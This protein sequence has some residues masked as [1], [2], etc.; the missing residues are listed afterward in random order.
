MAN[1]TLTVNSQFDPFSYQELLQPALMATQA[2]RELEDQYSTLSTEANIWDNLVNKEKDK[3]AYSLYKSF[4]DDLEQQVEQ[5]AREGL[6]TSS[7]KRLLNMKSRYSKDITPLVEAKNALREANTL[8]D[9]AGP[10][11]IFEVSRYNSL[12]DFLGGKTAN[13]RYQS[14]SAIT[15]K[16]AAITEA[17]MKEALQDPGFKEIPEVQQYMIT[18]HT[19]G[20][21]EDLMAAIANNPRAQSKFAAIKKQVMEEVDY[22]NY[23]TYGQA[24]IESAVNTGL[25]AGLDKP[26]RQFM[27]NKVIPPKPGDDSPGTGGSGTSRV[28]RMSKAIILDTEGKVRGEGDE[29]ALDKS[30]KSVKYSDLSSYPELEAV[31]KAKVGN[32]SDGYDYYLVDTSGIFDKEPKYTRIALVPREPKVVDSIGTMT[33]DQLSELLKKAQEGK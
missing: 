6:N 24:A 25:Y 12:D 18:T 17:V 20:S 26:V 32:D 4:S 14:A 5:L 11:A 28:N 27:A 10:D 19:G 1:Y 13:N 30:F 15:S 22:G 2:H 8:R 21:Y 29:V 9:K 33:L 16:T 3:K 31:A 23:D 7:R